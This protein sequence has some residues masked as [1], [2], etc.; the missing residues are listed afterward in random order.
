MDGELH[1]SPQKIL[2]HR[3][4]ND[5]PIIA[6]LMA[7]KYAIT[8]LMQKVTNKLINKKVIDAFLKTQ[9]FQLCDTYQYMYSDTS[10]WAEIKSHTSYVINSMGD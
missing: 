4:I 2:F 5:Q 3:A 1:L 9:L 7:G 8:L 6:L 10:M